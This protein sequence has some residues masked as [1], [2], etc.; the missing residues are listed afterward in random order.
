MAAK[1]VH[2]SYCSSKEDQAYP[3]HLLLFMSNRL[4]YSFQ[5]CHTNVHWCCGVETP[6]YLC[7]CPSAAPPP[8]V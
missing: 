2:I 8:P 6:T 4:T 7:F 5:Q 3:T 1:Q